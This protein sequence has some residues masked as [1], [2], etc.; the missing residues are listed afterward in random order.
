MSLPKCILL[1]LSG[2]LLLVDYNIM[3]D[4]A[5]PL[6]FYFPLRVKFFKKF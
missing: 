3:Q 6:Y 5:C 1:S 2:Q 4:S